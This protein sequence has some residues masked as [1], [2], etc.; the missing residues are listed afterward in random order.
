MKYW[1]VL[2]FA[3]LV[4]GAAAR[5]S[6]SPEVP[7]KAQERAVALKGGTL[8][9]VSGPEI[10]GGTI[11]FDAGK[12]VVLG[13]DVPVPANA[14]VIDVSGKHVYPGLIEAHTEL[15]LV[16][17]DAVRASR[18]VAEAGTI[19][20]NVKAQVAVNPDS[21]LI[22][23]ARSNGVLVAVTTPSG[24]LISGASAVMQLDG[25]TWEEMTLKAPSGMHVNWPGDD[26]LPGLR[27]VLADARA[28]LAA[29]NASG[30]SVPA[31]DARWEAMASVLEG[32]TPLV[33]R[34][35]DAPRIESAVAFAAQ[36]GLKL[37]IF[38]GYDAPLCAELLKQHEVPV[39]VA[40]IY[41]LPQRESDGYDDAY[42]VPARLHQAGVRFCISGDES[43]WNARN[44]AYHAA[45]AAAYGL[46]ADEAL[47]AVTLYPAQIFG[48][49]GQLGSLEAGKSAT[50]I[51][52][53]GDPLE[54]A[55]HVERA[56]IQGRAVDLSDKQKRLWEKYKEKY[57]RLG[58][59][60]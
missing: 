37:I 20:P 34:A 59:Q 14:D 15:G 6:G 60:N 12:I 2:V 4:G 39:I 40:G 48:I 55:T 36:E 10:A 13:S 18:D 23:V 45:T 29:K 51:V 31:V 42:T 24:G 26:G 1:L 27:R 43:A 50:L 58:I 28:Y 19:N 30:S 35:D 16:E 8:H 41:R 25:W 56:Y 3:V 57:R 32:R 33:V 22:P 47:K 38:G 53:S 7:G 52:T 5:V 44:L 21:E 11:V 54:I 46:P 9:P 49:D 17:I